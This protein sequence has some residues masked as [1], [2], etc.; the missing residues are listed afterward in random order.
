MIEYLSITNFKS[1]KRLYLKPARLNLCFGLNGMG[2]S[3]LLQAMLLLR[4]SHQRGVLE[5]KGLL[6]QGG[7]LVS[8][9]SGKDA[10]YQFAGKDE[11]L[12]FEIRTPGQGHCRWSFALDPGSDILPLRAATSETNAHKIGMQACGL[13]GQGFA[14]L[15]ADRMGPQKLYP[16]SD[17]EIATNRSIG[18]HGEFAAHYLS[19]YGMSEKV[20][21]DG[22]HH[23]MGNSD[24]LLHQTIGWLNEICPGTRLV[25]EDVKGADVIKLGFQFETQDGFT[26]EFSPLN[27]GFGIL[28]VLPVI[29]LLLRAKP[30]DLVLVENP[31]S[32]L[33]P[34]GQAAIGRLLAAAGANG[35]QIFCESHSDHIINGVRVA[36]KEK[37]LSPEKL[38]VYYFGRTHQGQE[39]K[40]E[41]TEIRVDRHGEL[42][43]YPPGL[44]DEWSELLAKL[45]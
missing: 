45:I 12:E 26:N 3:S 44:L 7:D 37:I 31:E 6:L 28:Y 18:L 39:H 33:H 35:V 15:C 8:I 21:Y 13:F 36:V 41:V 23:P 2:K 29:V 1:L 40:A 24:R 16:K 42:S 5:S 17:F 20:D 38:A 11:L 4:Q 27:V 25:A 10:F 19:R 32:H 30:G 9:G 14:Y 43:D 22:L 34:K